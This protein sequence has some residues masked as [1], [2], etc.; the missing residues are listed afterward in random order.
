M[1][2]SLRVLAG[3][4]STAGQRPPGAAALVPVREEDPAGVVGDDGVGRDPDV[5]A[6]PYPGGP[7]VTRPETPPNDRVSGL[8]RG[9]ACSAPTGS[10]A[11]SRAIARRS[12]KRPMAMV[13][14]PM[15]S[16]Q[17]GEHPDVGERGCPPSGAVRVEER[18]G[19]PPGV[20]AE[21]VGRE[22]TADHRVGD[23]GER[24]ADDHE[25]GLPGKATAPGREE[26]VDEE[27]DRQHD[28]QHL[29]GPVV[30]EGDAR[31]VCE[32]ELTRELPAAARCTRCRAAASD[33]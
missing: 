20:R 29:G 25:E 30:Q 9:Q 18:V 3:I 32:R 27:I 8:G 13:I 26:Q 22:F 2:G 6:S 33:P 7:V 1:G 4:E 14:A 12:R 10:A 5:H 11:A 23:P 19:I 15:P 17:A 31:S 28:V 24:I 21:G 16:E